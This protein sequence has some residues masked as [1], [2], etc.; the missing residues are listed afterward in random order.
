MCIYIY[1]YTHIHVHIHTLCIYLFINSFVDVR[2]CVCVSGEW[3]H[4]TD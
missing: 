1:I 3:A 2:M 4:H